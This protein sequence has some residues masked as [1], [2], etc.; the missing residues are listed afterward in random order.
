MAATKQCAG[1]PD[2]V[3]RRSGHWHLAPVVAHR[4]GYANVAP[5]IAGAKRPAAEPTRTTGAKSREPRPP[6]KV[7]R[8][9]RVR[10]NWQ[11]PALAPIQRSLAYAR[12]FEHPFDRLSRV[13]IASSAVRRS[14]GTRGLRGNARSGLRVALT[15]REPAQPHDGDGGARPQPTSAGSTS[16]LRQSTRPKPAMTWSASCRASRAG[17][18]AGLVA[19]IASVPSMRSRSWSAADAGS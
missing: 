8:P 5:R 4:S 19:P 3:A 6:G 1:P 15:S 2:P 16:R 12:P 14:G 13:P 10:L 18:V 7:G 17:L 9:S 11:S